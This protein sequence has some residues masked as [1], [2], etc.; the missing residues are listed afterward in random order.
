MQSIETGMLTEAS[1]DLC[2]FSTESFTTPQKKSWAYCR[3]TS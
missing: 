1:V 3:G 2:L